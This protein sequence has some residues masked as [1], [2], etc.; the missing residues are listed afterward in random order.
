MVS[1][2]PEIEN[3]NR[4]I[5]L[6]VEMNAKTKEIKNSLH[7]A[8]NEE[9]QDGWPHAASQLWYSF[10]SYYGMPSDPGRVFESKSAFYANSNFHKNAEFSAF[11]FQPELRH[12][13]ENVAEFFRLP[14]QHFFLKMPAHHEICTHF[15]PYFP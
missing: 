2:K 5:N 10:V 15:R 3:I 14:W 6:P 8:A 7:M 12:G 9:H 11:Y 1:V 13:A 4:R